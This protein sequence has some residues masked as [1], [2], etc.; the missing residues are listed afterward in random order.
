MFLHG[1]ACP[2]A[3]DAGGGGT[4]PHDAKLQQV[5]MQ[6]RR[7]GHFAGLRLQTADFMEKMRLPRP[8]ASCC[9]VGAVQGVAQPGPVLLCAAL[10]LRS[11]R[12][13]ECI[14][15]EAAG[16]RPHSFAASVCHDIQPVSAPVPF[17]A[18]NDL[19]H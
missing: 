2:H 10:S 5:L 13:R 16:P 6:V 19:F 17:P 18:Q 11:V 4:V 1:P 9:I 12:R 15:P 7:I 14:A 3:G 8:E